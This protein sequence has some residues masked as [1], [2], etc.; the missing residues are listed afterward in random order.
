MELD[1]KKAELEQE[2]ELEQ[3]IKFEQEKVIEIETEEEQEQEFEIESDEVLEKKKRREVIFEM[4]LFLILG[5]LLGVTIKT[6]AVKRITMGFNDYL[7]SKPAQSYDITELKKNLDDQI[8]QQ[9]AMQEQAA[10]Q[11]PAATTNKK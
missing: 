3:E 8:A 2:K 7:I 1:K 10:Q 11:A 5:I 9:Q 4:A 6:E